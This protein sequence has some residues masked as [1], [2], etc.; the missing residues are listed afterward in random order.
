MYPR[1]NYYELSRDAA[2]QYGPLYYFLWMNST[3]MA[4][5]LTPIAQWEK[6]IKSAEWRT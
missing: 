1:P 5:A 6:A 2:K 3:Y 4:D